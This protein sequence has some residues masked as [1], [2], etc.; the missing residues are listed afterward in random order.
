MLTF[1]G[2]YNITNNTFSNGLSYA[3]N[4]STKFEFNYFFKNNTLLGFKYIFGNNLR[5]NNDSHNFLI[6]FGVRF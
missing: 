5:W 2:I 4:F 6:N 1:Q 3:L